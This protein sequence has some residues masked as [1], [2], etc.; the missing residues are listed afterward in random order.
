MSYLEWSKEQD[1]IERDQPEKT[2]SLYKW[3]REI[4]YTH[5]KASKIYL[6]N[7]DFELMVPNN[8][9]TAFGILLYALSLPLL[10]IEDVKNEALKILES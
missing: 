3:A 5:P 8:K 1:S 6:S 7:S 4:F 2:Q 9:A 10:Q